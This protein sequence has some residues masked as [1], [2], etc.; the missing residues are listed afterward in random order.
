VSFDVAVVREQG[1]TFAVVAVK[2]HVLASDASRTEAAQSAQAR[3][4]R[5]PIILMSQ[6]SAGRP[7]FWGRPDIVRFLSRVAISRLPWRRFNS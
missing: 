4:P 5:M 6:S 2:S 3:F 1:Q 7:T